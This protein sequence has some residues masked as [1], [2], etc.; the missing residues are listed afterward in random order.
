MKAISASIIVLAGAVIL[1]AGAMVQ[2]SDTQIDYL[3]DRRAGGSR[4]V[5]G[6]VPSPRQERW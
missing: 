1:S 4:R 6:L 3:L 2:H 5:V